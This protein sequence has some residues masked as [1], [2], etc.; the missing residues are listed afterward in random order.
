VQFKLS[1]AQRPNIRTTQKRPAWSCTPA[2]PVAVHEP[3]GWGCWCGC[4][5]CHVRVAVC[6]AC[7]VCAAMERRVDSAAC[8]V[9]LRSI[10]LVI[11]FII[12]VHFSRFSLTAESTRASELLPLLLHPQHSWQ[13]A[14]CGG[15]GSPHTTDSSARSFL[16][17]SESY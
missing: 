4:A 10:L 9:S 11:C 17:P 6:D 5:M 15:V 2:F 8:A 16:L 7:H 12:P 13:S 14:V 1:Q 3:R